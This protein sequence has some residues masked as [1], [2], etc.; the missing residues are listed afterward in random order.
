MSHPT[1]NSNKMKCASYGKVRWM[2][3]VQGC[4]EYTLKIYLEE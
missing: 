4:D 2:Q 3:K 1:K